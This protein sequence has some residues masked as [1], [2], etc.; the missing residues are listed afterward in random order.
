LL[1]YKD[2]HAIRVA[3]ASDALG[4]ARSTAHRLLAMLQHFGFVR[5]NAR[6]RAY[7]AG[8][9]LMEI[10]MAVIA[11]MDVQA[12]VRPHLEKLVDD[13]G[14]TA[15]V[16]A[17]RG[18]DSV[19]LGCVESSKALRAGDRTGTALPAYA[20]SAGKAL[21]AALG[22]D[23]V[24]E[25]FPNEI[26]EPLTRRT[27]RTRTALLAELRRVRERGYA[28]NVDESETGLWAFGRAIR[29]RSGDVRAAITVSG[30]AARF[31]EL[32]QNQVA[33]A[34]QAACEAAGAE[35]R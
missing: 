9:A 35:I 27:I 31:R 6:T 1:L 21:L 4:V 30:P 8:P 3:E 5:Q 26:L 28:T 10:G 32:D 23:R 17:L 12:A 15:H 24:R 33:A 13:L 18:R 14:E 7:H 29:G 11:E 22:D 20:T 2:R 25:R 16:C 34:L 19:F